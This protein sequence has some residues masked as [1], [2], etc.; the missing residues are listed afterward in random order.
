[1]PEYGAAVTKDGEPV[2]TLT[3]PC[4]S[5]TLGQVIGM[6][7]LETRF[8][9]KGTTVEVAV[10]DGTATATVVRLPDLRPEKTRPRAL[11]PIGPSASRRRNSG[12]WPSLPTVTSVSPSWMTS[13]GCAP[14]TGS[15][16]RRIA[17]MVIPVRARN[18][19][20]ARVWP[21][22]GLPGGHRH[23]LDRQLSERHL[24]V[25]DDLRP[26]VGAAE[27]RTELARLVVLELEHRLRLVVVR[28]REEVELPHAVDVL[29]HGHA[30]AVVG[31]EA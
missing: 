14:V 28:A 3:S 6:A 30:G 8:A 9:K 17:M 27:H 20:S 5:P 19:Q 13:V 31:L 2:G 24:E 18:P 10:G 1:M 12:Y 7:V 23:P 22:A 16:S 26:L 4:E 29:D 21:I 11:G 15:G 25:L